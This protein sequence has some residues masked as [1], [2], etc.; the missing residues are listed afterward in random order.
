MIA[1]V[2]PNQ[3]QPG[4]GLEPEVASLAHADT[5]TMRLLWRKMFGSSAPPAFRRDILA[6]A[7][8]YRTQANLK[9][10]VTFGS[11]HQLVA[12][13]EAQVPIRAKLI[14]VWR[15][16][17]YEVVTAGDAFEMNGKSYRSL[18]A[19]AREITGVRWNGLTFFGVR[20]RPE[21]SRRQSRG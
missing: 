4:T 10:D 18:S 8:A 15:G 7:I 1:A 14:R 11:Q 19:I 12:K 16:Q 3:Y 5:A 20:N 17:V 2:S 13:D 9:G 21:L 6:R